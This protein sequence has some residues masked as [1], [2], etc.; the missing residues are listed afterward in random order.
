M[1]ADQVSTRPPQVG[2]HTQYDARIKIKRERP[3][4]SVSGAALA[5]DRHT[6]TRRQ[7]E[8]WIVAPFDPQP[9]ISS[10]DAVGLAAL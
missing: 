1:N 3:R 5:I 9:V 6:H 8:C 7:P 2:T 10:S 4:L